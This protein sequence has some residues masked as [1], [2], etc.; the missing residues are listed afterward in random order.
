M[1]IPALP[2]CLEARLQHAG[3]CGHARLSRLKVRLPDNALHLNNSMIG[4]RAESQ[5]LETNSGINNR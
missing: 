2:G 3:D 1:C 4:R 5:Q